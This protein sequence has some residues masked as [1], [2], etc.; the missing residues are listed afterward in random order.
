MTSASRRPIRNAKER[1]EKRGRKQ[2]RKETRDQTKLGRTETRSRLLSPPAAA[3]QILFSVFRLPNWSNGFAPINSVHSSSVHRTVLSWY[4]STMGCLNCLKWIVFVFNF[5]FWVTHSV[6]TY[7]DLLG[8]CTLRGNLVLE[9]ERPT[10]NKASTN[11][12][13]PRTHSLNNQSF[14]RVFFSNFCFSN[15]IR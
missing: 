1:K 6:C 7:A 5:I 3:R 12:E 15:I 14:L 11:K 13:N 9:R 8:H 2:E 10:R 4:F